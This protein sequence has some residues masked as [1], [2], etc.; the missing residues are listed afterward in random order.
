[1]KFSPAQKDNQLSISPHPIGN[2]IFNYIAGILPSLIFPILPRVLS[3]ANS[4]CGCHR[5]QILQ[6]A[7]SEKT[8][9][10]FEYFAKCPEYWTI[11][12]TAIPC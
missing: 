4:G 9:P 1:M 3:L 10:S 6:Y 12:W 2:N 11:A 5:E 7:P 8:D